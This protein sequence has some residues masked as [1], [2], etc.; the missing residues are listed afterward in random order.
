VGT[1]NTK[2]NATM[3]AGVIFLEH[4]PS[5]RPPHTGSLGRGDCQR[6]AGH[7]GDE[8]SHATRQGRANSV[9][10]PAR[11]NVGLATEIGKHQEATAIKSEFNPLL[12]LLH[13]DRLKL[14]RL[15]NNDA[16]IKVTNPELLA[17]I[18]FRGLS[19]H[20]DPHAHETPDHDGVHSD[21][22]QR[23]TSTE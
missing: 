22:I 7:G 23:T 16:A 9:L 10:G 1:T 21:R 11:K 4:R 17:K 20:A 13:N 8:S 12:R 2:S 3:L 18:Q 15:T 19:S 14:A 5:R 6:N